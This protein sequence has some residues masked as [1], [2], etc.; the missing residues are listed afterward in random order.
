MSRQYMVYSDMI[1][2]EYFV[3]ENE[4]DDDGPPILMADNTDIVAR[5]PQIINA[6][7]NSCF[8]SDSEKPPRKRRENLGGTQ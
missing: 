3:A 4:F 6:W 1:C 5:A 8:A 7:M 2:L